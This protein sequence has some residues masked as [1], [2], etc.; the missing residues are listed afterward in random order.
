MQW[1][2]T[3]VATDTARFR[4]LLL[5]AG[6]VV[7][8]LGGMW[9]DDARALIY[10][11]CAAGVVLLVVV[12]K[13]DYLHPA[14]AY[15]LPWLTVLLFST[16]PISTLSR[17]LQYSTCLFLL[18]A[19]LVWLLSTVAAPVFSEKRTGKISGIAAGE[20]PEMIF[21]FKKG[22]F[23]AFAVLYL[24]AA[25]NVAYA[26]YVPLFSLLRGGTGDNGYATF[27]IPSVYGAFLAYANAV[28]CL[29]FYAYLR[30][31]S[32]TYLWL[33]V[34]VIAMHLLLVNR[35]N[36][37]TLSVEAFV[38]RSL[39]VR[40]LSKA[41][42]LVFIAVGLSALGALGELRSGDI[43][44]TIGVDAAYSWVPLGAVWLYAYSYFNVLNLEN[45]MVLSD[46]PYYDGSMWQNLLPT[47]LRPAQEHASYLELQAMN[48][49]S[50]IYPI[51][52]D[53]GRAGVL[54]W[55]GIWGLITTY[56]YRRAL[57]HRRFVHVTTYACLFFCALLSFFVAF[58]FYLP[59]IFQIAF[60]WLFE[61][62]L[63]KRPATKRVAA[64]A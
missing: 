51:Y 16:I 45:T 36:V 27:G 35:Q 25:F 4:F 9:L 47:I 55:T 26:G 28:G 33:F 57:A 19:V 46:A 61:I 2:L 34:S 54:L 20:E 37:I 63:F 14:V 21:G 49:S 44:T 17:E 6:A 56:V 24:F 8:F 5:V 7:V 58:W 53:V 62:L 29:G 64:H 13:F 12:Y 39:M 32:R 15:V 60:F 38:I 11:G 59:V 10:F 30:T 43:R 31:H 18:T 50:Y 52:T 40:R 41:K 23:V 22:A 48:V 42:I 3:K 1:A